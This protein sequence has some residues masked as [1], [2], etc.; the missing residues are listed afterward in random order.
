MVSWAN[1]MYC[2]SFCFPCDDIWLQCGSCSIHACI[3]SFSLHQFAENGC[4]YNLYQGYDGPGARSHAGGTAVRH[5]GQRQDQDPRPWGDPAW[6]T[7]PCFCG[8]AARRRLHPGGLQHSTGIHDWHGSSQ[9][10]VWPC[11]RCRCRGLR[12]RVAGVGAR[13]RSPVGPRRDAIGGDGPACRSQTPAWW[14]PPRSSGTKLESGFLFI[15]ASSQM[16]LCFFYYKCV[17]PP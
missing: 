1:C 7:M 13:V 14:W 4:V 17:V 3:L 12:P 11:R 10:D 8:P 5:H 2:G 16:L 15:C 6:P 9:P